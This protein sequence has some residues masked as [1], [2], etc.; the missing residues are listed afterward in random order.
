MNCKTCGYRLWNLTSRT[1]P[2]CGSP[3]APSEFEFSPNEVQFCCPQCEQV[4]YGTSPVGHLEPREFDCV[5][6]G[7]H[8]DMDEMILRPADWSREEMTSAQVNRWLER[9]KRGRFKSF[10]VTLGW[11]MARP[12]EL[13]R[14]TPHDSSM[15]HA[16]WYLL[17]SLLL[18]TMTCW[19]PAVVWFA[20]MFAVIAPMS[21]GGA[22]LGGAMVGVFTF[23]G[24]L[25]II[26]AVL[27]VFT[28]LWG[29]LAHLLMFK[30]TT[31]I[32]RTYQAICYTVG[33]MCLMAIPCVG[34]YMI[35]VGGA[36]WTI[37]AILALRQAQEI[38]SLR[39]TIAVGTLPLL[40][41]AGIVAL[42]VLLIVQATRITGN[43]QIVML[44]YALQSYATT[45]TNASTGQGPAHMLELVNQPNTGF[46]NTT[47]F[48]DWQTYTT[49]SK[50]QLSPNLTLEQFELAPVAQQQTMLQAL[51]QAQPANVVAHRIGDY[52]FT[53]HGIDLNNA[54][55]GL[56][57]IVYHPDPVVNPSPDPNDDCTV[58]QADMSNTVFSF[59]RL[60]S[61]L[62][63]Q[64]KL[65][66]TLNLPPLPDPAMVADYPP[67]TPGSFTAPASTPVPAGSTA[68]A[69]GA[70]PSTA[71]PSNGV[72]TL[73][74]QAVP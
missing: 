19:L 29:G 68:P 72:N 26:P 28:L 41:F 69:P 57:L 70:A 33:P 37:C 27:V 58:V 16:W 52:V 43:Q 71:S 34:F 20:L 22:G 62:A 65:R 56:W 13:L 39:A 38:R 11:G 4:Y 15:G 44:G 54:D 5:T 42:I 47:Q 6:C 10:F 67:A 40:T 49:S 59:S 73:P 12:G 74:A 32:R 8:V 18:F 30:P 61:E 50:V 51:V 36:W 14:I 1:C 64:N 21:S 60:S 35:P 45:S 23:A 66:G 7:R 48:I 46:I 24:F 25:L 63:Q 17:L 2:E 9:R 55:P 3:F 53:Y 31:R